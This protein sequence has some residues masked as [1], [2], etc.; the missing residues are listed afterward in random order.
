MAKFFKDNEAAKESLQIKDPYKLVALQK[1][2]KHFD[3]KN[4]AIEA[5]RTLYLANMAKYTQ[6]VDA[7]QKLL[8]TYNDVLGEASYN[9]TWRIGGSLHDNRCMYPR[10]WSGRNAM[11]NIL[12]NIRDILNDRP[13]SDNYISPTFQ[14]TSDSHP[15]KTCWYCGEFNHISKNCQHGQKVCCN[16]CLSLGHKAKFCPGY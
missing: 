16:S 8:S 4:W 14:E 6:N 12:M 15:K 7:R 3:R 10:N 2:I 11:G 13:P 1:N 9:R 5:E